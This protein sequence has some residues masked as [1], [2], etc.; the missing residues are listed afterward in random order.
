MRRL[1]TH[2]QD[3]LFYS[4]KAAPK[5]ANA[6]AVMHGLPLLLV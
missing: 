2:T 1:L 4:D 3:G 5:E 6:S